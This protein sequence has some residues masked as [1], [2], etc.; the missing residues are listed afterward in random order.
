MP[1]S[2]KLQ[3][4]SDKNTNSRIKLA[5]LKSGLVLIEGTLRGPLGPKIME[6]GVDE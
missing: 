3:K 6:I 5:R 1:D 4:S 2:A